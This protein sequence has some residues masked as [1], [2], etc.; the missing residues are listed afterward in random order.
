MT[1]WSLAMVFLTS[2]GSLEFGN[3]L[4]AARNRRFISSR[5][6]FVNSSYNWSLLSS[7]ISWVRMLNQATG[8]R[9]GQPVPDNC[10]SGDGELAGGQTQGLD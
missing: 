7:L 5:P 10:F 8:H 9:G 2:D 6:D 4:V 3:W 1:V